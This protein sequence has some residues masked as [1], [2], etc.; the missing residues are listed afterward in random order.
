VTFA[1][2][3]AKLTDLEELRERVQALA[4]EGRPFGFDVETG[5][6]GESRER[7]SLHRE[8]NFLVAFQ[9]TNELTWARMVPLRF[10]SGV[11]CDNR[12]VAR[13]LWPLFHATGADGKPLGVAHGA[14]A[15]LRW[16]SRWFLDYLGDDPYY[17]AAVREAGGYFPIRSCSLIE[18]YVEAVNQKHGLKVI[19]AK[20]PFEHK[21]LE[22][23]DLYPKKLTEKQKKCIRFNELDPDD[24]RVIEYACED[25]LWC[26][27]HHLYRYPKVSASLIYAIEM[28]VLPVIAEMADNGVYYD[29]NFMREA[30]RRTHEFKDRYLA[31]VVAEFSALAGEQVSINFNSPQ[32]FGNLL[33][34]KCGMPVTHWTPGGKPSVD[35]KVALPTLAEQYPAVKK[36]LEWTKLDTL[37]TNFLDTYEGRHSYA[38]DGRA[39]PILNGFGRD[40]NNSGAFGT[41]TGRFSCEDPNYQQSPKKYKYTLATGEEYFLNYRDVI[42]APPG[43]YILGYDYSQI[44]LRVLAGE[45]QEP[46]LLEAFERGI[47]VH[48]LTASLMLGVPLEQVTEEQRAV[49]K[50]MNFALVY[51]MSEKGLADRLGISP[52]EAEQKFAEYFAAYPRVKV[53]MDRTVSASKRDGFVTTKWGRKVP[54]WEYLSSSYRVRRDGERTAGNAPIQGSATGDYVK[55]SMVR[56]RNAIRKAGLADRV[57]LVMN[58]HDALE[59][60]VDRSVPPA[61][62]V[63]V[64]QPAVVWPVE[65]WPAMVAEWHIG[66]R[67]GSVKELEV[68]PD[69]SVRL[70]KKGA[71]GSTAGGPE[72]EKIGEAPPEPVA[73]EPAVPGRLGNGHPDRSAGAGSGLPVGDGAA[74]PVRK[75]IITVPQ[76]PAQWQAQRLAALLDSVPGGNSVELRA[77]GESIPFPRPTGLTPDMGPQVSILLGGATVRYAPESVDARALTAGIAL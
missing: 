54:I 8:E 14:V 25:A 71:A 77:G 50:T 62:V 21:M 46:A 68:L 37:C 69:G 5:Y 24:P 29:W 34:E 52:A 70:K 60:Y 45:A 28:A 1:A 49:G 7:G 39:H 12:E 59:F 43:W 44:E 27:A 10:N 35:A 65:G 76:I 57:K 56:A 74:G 66:E 61:A 2:S 41:I 67:W 64:L 4:A 22:L 33:Y 26:L 42:A 6:D 23:D 40:E 63:A 48:S 13:I 53:W 72:V 75:V 11:N 17:G 32:Q 3:Y 18:S 55:I 73:A 20:P 16:M 9:F 36:Y 58:V 15:E 31:E 19:T 38:P 51:G 47:D 30:S